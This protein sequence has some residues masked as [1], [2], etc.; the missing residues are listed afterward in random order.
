MALGAK[1]ESVLRSVLRHGFLLT[2]V[3]LALGVAA[4]IGLTRWM[5]TLLFGVDAIDPWTFIAMACVIAI[6]VTLAS[7]VPA[8]RAAR[9][10]PIVALRHQ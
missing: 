4:S 6:V 3:S 1:P 9:V 2:L 10:D 5:R 7:Y 8:R